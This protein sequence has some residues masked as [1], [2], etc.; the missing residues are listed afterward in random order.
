MRKFLK[1]ARLPE[2]AKYALMA[3]H[4]EPV[5]NKKTGKMPTAEEIAKWQRTTP[6]LDE[7]LQTNGLAKVADMIVYV[8]GLK[9]PLEE[10]WQTKVS[11]FADRI[12]G[13]S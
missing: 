13:P 12:L 7:I 5:P 1:K 2:G 10:G 8:T 11:A 9:G 4:G 6:I 3:T